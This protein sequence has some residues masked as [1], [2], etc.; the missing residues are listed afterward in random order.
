MYRRDVPGASV[1]A[2]EEQE[3]T[4]LSLTNSHTHFHSPN[5]QPR[6]ER[7]SDI[8]SRLLKE[9]IVCLMGPVC[10]APSAATSAR[11]LPFLSARPTSTRQYC[12]LSEPPQCLQVT[13]DVAAVVVAQLLFLESENPAKPVYM[14]INSPGGSVTAG[15]AIYDTMQY[16]Q[17]PVSTV[18]IGQ[19]CSMG[20]LLLAAGEPGKRHAL[21]YARVMVH[22]P[23][24]SAYVCITLSL[25]MHVSSLLVSFSLF[26]ACVRLC[27]CVLV[28][29][30]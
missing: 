6:G 1:A 16:I 24:G 22:Q 4:L 30:S 28:C 5:A 12:S 10:S 19:A 18:C 20:S 15:M 17:A 8:F 29:R 27:L 25:S 14:Y 2:L 7:Y 3:S 26:C 21:P 9:R 11:T 13:D 23:S